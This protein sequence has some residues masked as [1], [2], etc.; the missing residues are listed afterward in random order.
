MFCRSFTQ[1]I[2]RALRTTDASSTSGTIRG[3]WLSW[4][5]AP[6][7]WV[8]TA[9]NLSATSVCG[10]SHEPSFKI[11]WI[12]NRVG[13]HFICMEPLLVCQT[14]TTCRFEWWFFIVIK[15]SNAESWYYEVSIISLSPTFMENTDIVLLVTCWPVLSLS[16]F[17][18]LQLPLCWKMWRVNPKWWRRRS[19]GLCCPSSQWAV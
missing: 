7:L 17:F 8:E 14:L 5:G 18:L 1:I 11:S 16:F 2:Q 6:S 10:A 9:M 3:S 4:R 15:D 19:S 13:L 12:H